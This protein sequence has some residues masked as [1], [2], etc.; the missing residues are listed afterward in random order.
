[1]LEVGKPF[2][3]QI[4]ALTYA[5][6]GP[7]SLIATQALYQTSFIESCHTVDIKGTRVLA[8][9]SGIVNAN[10]ENPL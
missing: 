10:A 1:M 2:P 6:C 9:V 8:V 7:A 4:P 3:A 5:L